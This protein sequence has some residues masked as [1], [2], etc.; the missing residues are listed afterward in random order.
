VIEK[1]FALTHAYGIELTII[2]VS[3]NDNLLSRYGEQ[4]PVLEIEDK[5]LRS[6]FDDE[7]MRLF[8]DKHS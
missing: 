6:P 8:L 7:R 5:V 4:I 3:L 2:D 1:L